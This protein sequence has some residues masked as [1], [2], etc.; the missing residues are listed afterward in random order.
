MDFNWYRLAAILLYLG[1]DIGVAVYGRYIESKKSQVSYSAHFA[2]AVVGFFVG[3]NVLR[4][5]KRRRW[6][7]IFGWTVLSLYII[8]MASA[9][10]FNI[11]NETYFIDPNDPDRCKRDMFNRH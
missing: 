3:V 10:L 8:F 1:T 2:G 9:I 4:N 7:V 6:E 5:L 11:L